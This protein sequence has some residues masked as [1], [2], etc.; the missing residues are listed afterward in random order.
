MKVNNASNLYCDDYINKMSIEK[1]NFDYDIIQ[2]INIIKDYY[3]NNFERLSLINFL[4]FY[5]N[6][7]NEIKNIFIT[8]KNFTVDDLE[9]FIN[10]FIKIMENESIF[11]FDY[12]DKLH[13]DNVNIRQKL[14]LYFKNKLNV[15]S[16]I[17]EYYNK[18]PLILFSYSI[19]YNGRGFN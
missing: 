7:F 9:Q 6:D 3:N 8:C 18:K 14:E 12:W 17:F 13:K 1:Y 10:P 4:P 15:Y 11:Y 2:N 5:S 16:C 19:T